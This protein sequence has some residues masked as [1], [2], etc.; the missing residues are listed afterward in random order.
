MHHDGVHTLALDIDF[1][2][3]QTTLFKAMVGDVMLLIANHRPAAEQRVAVLTVLGIGIGQIDGL[4]T[5]RRQI[6]GLWHLGPAVE[7]IGLF[8]VHLAHFLQADDVSIELLHSQAQVVNLQP[9]RRAQALHTLVDV[10]SGHTQDLRLLGRGRQNISHRLASFQV[11][12]ST[13]A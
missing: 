12:C 1:Y 3:Q 7:I 6:F 2:M 10:V 11:C 13:G 8:V 4:I 5:F 9:T